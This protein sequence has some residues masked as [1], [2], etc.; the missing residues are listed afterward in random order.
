MPSK[1]SIDRSLKAWPLLVA[2]DMD[3]AT[4]QINTNKPPRPNQRA[5]Q[6]H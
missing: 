5:S 6:R 4:V 2:G 1:S 3:K